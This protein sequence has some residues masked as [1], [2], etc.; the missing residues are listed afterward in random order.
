MEPSIL[1]SVK[2]TLGLSAEYEAFDEDVIIQINSALAAL[3]QLGVGP[4]EGYMIDS[5][6]ETWDDFLADQISLLSLVKTYI[7]LK[8]SLAFDPP[9]IGYLIDAKNKQIEE[10]AF[11]ITVF[12]E[13]LLNAG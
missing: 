2:K 5:I 13:E 11:R 8:V 9:Q 10:H 7:C 1:I 6:S 3:T 4:E 12:R